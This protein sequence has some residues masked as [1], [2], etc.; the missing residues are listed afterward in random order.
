[1]YGKDGIPVAKVSQSM[2][3]TAEAPIRISGKS[4]GHVCPCVFIEQN[5]LS[6][7]YSVGLDASGLRKIADQLVGNKFHE[8]QDLILPVPIFDSC[9]H[10]DTTSRHQ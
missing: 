7:E 4:L 2:K 1:M 9:L 10:T 3:G 5:A 8:T 6:L